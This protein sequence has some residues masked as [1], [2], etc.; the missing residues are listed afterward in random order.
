[1]NSKVAFIIL[2]IGLALSAS[3]QISSDNKPELHG[4]FKNLQEFSF[5]NRVGTLHNTGLIH[6]RLN[7]KWKPDQQMTIRLEARSRFFYGDQVKL[8]PGFGELVSHDPG[9]LDLTGLWID[10]A[11][12]A[13][14]TALDRVQLNYR[15]NKVSVTLGRQRI[16]WGINNIWNTN[17]LFNAYDFLDYDYEERPGSDAIRIQYYKGLSTT[18]EIAAVPGRYEKGI[19][20]GRIRTN[21]WRYDLQLI[22]GLYKNDLAIGGGWAGNILNAGFKGEV[23]YFKDVFGNSDEGSFTGSI[24]FDYSFSNSWYVSASMLYVEDPSPVLLGLKAVE[25]GSLSAKS[26]MPYRW[27]G[28]AGFTKTFTP[29]FNASLALIYSPTQNSS[30]VFPS[31]NYSV[32]QNFDLTLA[33]QSFFSYEPGNFYNV[34]HLI[35]I[36]FSWNF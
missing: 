35:M 16:N 1:M 24:M 13:G 23:T 3:G 22:G 31:I 33:S 17:D 20:A 10:E 21:K 2:F 12:I 5:T 11:T 27:S 15:T 14:V 32:A 6:N 19:V 29:L 34:A 8:I 26:L 18:F 25:L 9:Y 28:Y 4:Y 36:R 7:F 30:I